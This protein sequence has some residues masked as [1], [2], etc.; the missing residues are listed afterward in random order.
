MEHLYNHKQSKKDLAVLEKIAPKKATIDVIERFC[1]ADRGDDKVIIA[2]NSDQWAYLKIGNADGAPPYLVNVPRLL[3]ALKLQN[4]VNLCDYHDNKCLQSGSDF[5]QNPATDLGAYKFG[6]NSI[7]AG[8]FDGYNPFCSREETRY[9]LRGVFITKTTIAA[10][11]G[12]I[13]RTNNATGNIE[14]ESAILPV[15]LLDILKGRAV[16]SLVVFE[17]RAVVNTG[18]ITVVSGLTDGQYPDYQRVIPDRDDAGFLVE[19]DWQ[20]LRDV[21]RIL[22]PKKPASRGSNNCYVRFENGV[23]YYHDMPLDIAYTVKKREHLLG[24]FVDYVAPFNTS[25]EGGYVLN[26]LNAIDENYGCTMF[27]KAIGSPFAVT[28]ND[29]VLVM[30]PLRV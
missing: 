1:V 6:N 9:Y 12:H 25:F 2:T 29:S 3:T 24:S 22:K 17:N 5:P 21:L 30:M 4:E 13:L 15:E 19:F 10:T 26:I 18:R 28:T 14:N 23:V 27:T 11:N 8:I 16:D 20:K 7:P